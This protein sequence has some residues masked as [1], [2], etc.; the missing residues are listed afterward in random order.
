MKRI[1]AYLFVISAFALSACLGRSQPSA[2][3]TPV[4]LFTATQAAQAATATLAAPATAAVSATAAP[5]MTPT[6]TAV[7]ASATPAAV[8]ATAIPAAAT[9]NPNEAV[10]DV[11]YHDKLDGKGGWFW[12]FADEV[13]TFGVADGK[14]KGTMKAANSGW[15]FTISPDT[16]Q[17][18]SQQVSLNAHSV[19]CGPNDEYGLMFRVTAD[20]SSTA[21]DGYLF[22]VRCDGLASFQVISGTQTTQVVGW[23]PSAA[24][25]TGGPADNTLL[26]WAAGSQLTLLC[27]LPGTAQ[28]FR[29]CMARS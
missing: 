10:G 25:K 13:A 29:M 24:I 15:R 14:L 5:T 9:P 23:T 26:V 18:G 7:P 1:L 20:A 4:P 11:V 28:L 17:L 3:A 6:A 2:T 12:T 16:L 22:K 8:G 19:A 27:V 21:F